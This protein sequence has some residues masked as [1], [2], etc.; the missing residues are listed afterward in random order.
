MVEAVESSAEASREHA[1]GESP[2][3]AERKATLYQWQKEVWESPGM[4][5]PRDL[6]YE[7]MCSTV[8]FRMLWPMSKTTLD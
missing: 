2:L 7:R 6:D 8:H 5:N 3:A 1:G 4:H